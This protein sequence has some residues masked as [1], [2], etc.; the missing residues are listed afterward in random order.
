MMLSLFS[1]LGALGATAAAQIS[2]KKY[3]MEHGRRTLCLTIVL[4]GIAPP[5]TYLAVKGFG[6]GTV[7]MST[8]I[9]YVLVALAGWRMFGEKPTHRR[10][11]G[12]GFVLVGILVYG[13]GL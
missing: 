5:L 3:S 10:I 8:A 2:Y 9:T 13:I 1:L 4:F 7:Y 12:M 11:V 6:V